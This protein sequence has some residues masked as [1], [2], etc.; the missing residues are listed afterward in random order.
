MLRLHTCIVSTQPPFPDTQISYVRDAFRVTRTSGERTSTA[1]CQVWTHP[2][3]W[4]LRLSLEGDGLK[5][6]AVARS[7][8]EMAET[9]EDWR[10]EMVANGWS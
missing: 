6:F 3:G 7:A 9:A 10:Q 5:R 4:E 8:V 2:A 1:V